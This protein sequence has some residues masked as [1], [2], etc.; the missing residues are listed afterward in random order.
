[1]Q[2]K[3][4]QYVMPDENSKG[5]KNGGIIGQYPYFAPDA[6]GMKKAPK[7]TKADELY[8]KKFMEGRRFQELARVE[9]MEREKE[10]AKL[11]EDP[12]DDGK[13]KVTINERLFEERRRI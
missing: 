13:V 7:M 3:N 2:S 12:F 1:M 10:L 4:L 8:L 6:V 9:E 11:D 5:Q